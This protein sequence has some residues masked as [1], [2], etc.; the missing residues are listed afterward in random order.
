MALFFKKNNSR[1]VY[2]TE[3]TGGTTYLGDTT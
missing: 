2:P 3:V 1:R